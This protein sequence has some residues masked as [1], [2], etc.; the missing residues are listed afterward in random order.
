MY[1]EENIP[2][3]ANILELNGYIQDRLRKM[4]FL[5]GEPDQCFSMKEIS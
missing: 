5:S 3:L 4:A 2:V 1:I